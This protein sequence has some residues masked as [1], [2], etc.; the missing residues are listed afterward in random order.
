MLV[1]KFKD[2]QK[3]VRGHIPGKGNKPVTEEQFDQFISN[4]LAND[5]LSVKDSIYARD[6]FSYVKEISKHTYQIIAFQINQFAAGAFADEMVKFCTPVM[7]TVKIHS[8]HF[9]SGHT[10]KDTNLSFEQFYLGKDYRGS[11]GDQCDRNKIAGFTKEL[12][13]KNQLNFSYRHEIIYKLISAN[14]ICHHVAETLSYA[15]GALDLFW[16]TKKSNVYLVSGSFFNPKNKKLKIEVIDNF[17][18]ETM[19]CFFDIPHY[20]LLTNQNELFRENYNL[21][22]W[23]VLYK[24]ERENFYLPVG[25]Q[26]VMKKKFNKA[27]NVITTQHIVEYILN[28]YYKRMNLHVVTNTFQTLQ[29]LTRGIL[30]KMEGRDAECMALLKSASSC[31]GHYPARVFSE[32]WNVQQQKYPLFISDY[33]HSMFF[34]PPVL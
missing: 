22:Q 14:F 29:Y 9:Y 32:V 5:T 11:K 15:L 6:G 31:M 18:Y 1:K 27:A 16:Y 7:I 21:M 28:S 17:S 26:K 12:F 23:E 24:R 10:L 2:F 30:A 19:K 25:Y 20:S 4:I 13:L 3:H 8:T 34:R 33:I